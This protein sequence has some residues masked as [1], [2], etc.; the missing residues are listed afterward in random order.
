MA[1]IAE[2]KTGIITDEC[3]ACDYLEI[4]N[5]ISYARAC[6]YGVAFYEATENGDI[7][8]WVD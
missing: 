6:G 1:Y 3:N 8:I 2:K 5:M 7:V 4:E